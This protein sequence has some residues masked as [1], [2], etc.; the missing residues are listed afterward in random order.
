MEFPKSI[1]VPSN[2]SPTMFNDEAITGAI[3]GNAVG[4]SNNGLFGALAGGAIGG[5][6]GKERMQ[7]EYTEGRV[8]NDPGPG[9]VGIVVSSLVGAFAAGIIGAALFNPVGVVLALGVGTIGGAMVGHATHKNAVL[10][11][12]AAKTY[13][14]EHGGHYQGRERE[15]QVGQAVTAEEY[16]VLKQRLEAMQKG[17]HTDRYNAEPEVSPL[18][19]R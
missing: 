18:K 5:M 4:G 9:T 8:V 2:T 1:R 7:R 14:V 12:E 3:I 6:F 13:F 19:T 16:R 17:T 15:A 11:Y 10:D